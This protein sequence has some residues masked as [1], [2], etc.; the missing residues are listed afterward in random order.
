MLNATRKRR[1]ALQVVRESRLDPS[2]PQSSIAKGLGVS[3]HQQ[4]KTS[5][6]KYIAEAERWLGAPPLPPDVLQALQ[7]EDP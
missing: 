2:R 5:W 4:R 1:K 7:E 3:A 6:A